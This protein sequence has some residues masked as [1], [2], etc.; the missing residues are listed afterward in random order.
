MEG[1]H[2]TGTVFPIRLSVSRVDSANGYS[3]MGVVRRETAETNAVVV[4]DAFGIIKSATKAVV[5]LFG[6]KS[7]SDF[8][9]KNVQ[10][11]RSGGPLV[12]LT[13]GSDADEP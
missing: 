2:K 12:Y 7:P 3:F 5:D 4:I 13:V 8:E 1:L 10:V 9:G 6:Y 11:T